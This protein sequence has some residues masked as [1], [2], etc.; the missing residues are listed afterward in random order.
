MGSP[1]GSLDGSL[2]GSLHSQRDG[3]VVD[4][5][6]VTSQSRMPKKRIGG[7]IKLQ[8]APAAVRPTGKPLYEE[9]EDGDEQ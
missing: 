3:S 8:Y 2:D 5:A 7:K 9:D 1:K 4:S 6:S